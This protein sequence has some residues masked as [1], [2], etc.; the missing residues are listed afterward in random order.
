MRITSAALTVILASIQVTN[1]FVAPGGK[2]P[3]W[4][5]HQTALGSAVENNFDKISSSQGSLHDVPPPVD[6]ETISPPNFSDTGFI[7]FEE[8]EIGEQPPVVPPVASVMNE[9]MEKAMAKMREKDKTSYDLKKEDLQVVF[10]DDH[11]I[12]VEKPSGVLSVPTKEVTASL[13]KSVFEAVGNESGEM[14]RMVVHRLG[15]DTSGVMVFA[16][17]EDALR[18]LNTAYRTRKVVRKYEALL[19]G[20]VASNAGQINLPL[21][22]DF[23]YPP[24]IRVSTDD[25]QRALIGLTIEDVGR[26][27]LELPKSS[28]TK[29]EVIARE[30]L[31]GHPVTRVSLTSVTGRTHQL[32]VHCAAFG[33]PIVGDNVYGIDGEAAPHGGL[34]VTSRVDEELQRK[35]KAATEGS[36]VRI[37]ARSIS[38]KHPV[39]RKMVT[40]ES[41]PPF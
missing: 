34:A 11:F 38:F 4:G 19:C 20:H 29:Y 15:M 40:I 28:I 5:N 33:H 25:H 22:R 23:D 2:T 27:L 17:T 37:H 16:K 6:V 32:N 24:Y 21:M 8:F 12:A 26:T 18:G 3:F 30:E 36:P 39:T 10:E 41:P 14:D 9:K 7:P 13:T 1:A 35:I 31:N